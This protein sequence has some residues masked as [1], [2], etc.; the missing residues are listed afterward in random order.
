[1]KKW[2]IRNRKTDYRE[3]AKEFGISEIVSKLL[4]NRDI[5]DKDSI[6]SFINP[7]YENFHNPREMK[8]LVKGVRIIKQKI[9]EGKK[10]MVVGDYDVDGVISLFELYTALKRCS[11]DVVYEIPDRIKDGYGINESIIDKAYDIGV[12]TIIT[13]DN[14]IASI[15]TIKHGKQLDMTIIVT[16][17]HDIPFVETEGGT[18]KNISSEA[19]AIINPKQEDCNYKFKLLCGAGVA[20]KFIEV[21]YEE[22]GID[23]SEAYKF[24][25]Y[26][27]IATVCD[28]VDLTSENRIFVKNGLELLNE[29]SNLGLT[30]LIKVTGIENKEISVYHLGFVI[31]PSLNAAGRLDSAKKGVALLLSDN[32]EEAV[33]LAKE[34]HELNIQRKDITQQG[35]ERAIEYIENNKMMRDK[36]LVVYTPE[37]H[38]S[39]AGIVAGRIREKYNLPAIVLTKAK[40]GVKGSAR[41]IEVY[42]MF[43][44]LNKC[45]ELLGPFG[46]H[47]MAAGLSL[48]EENI[49]ELRK[50]LNIQTTLTDEDIIP[51][52]YL[53][54]QL[55]LEKID[56]DLINDLSTLEPFGKGNS[57]PLF[58]EKG[59]T[60]VRGT[61]LGKNKNVLKLKMIMRNGVYIDGI[62]F[63]DINEFED[64]ITDKYGIDELNRLYNGNCRLKLDM[65]FYPSINEFNGRVSIQIVVENFR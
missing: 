7:S 19:D 21:L 65:V 16:D 33:K 15:D 8:D 17:H 55:P 26:I 49:L 32:Q 13:C 6:K 39:I 41:S 29:T 31:G 11:A 52:L 9:E 27:A 1:L 56:Y 47:P 46:G 12:D 24:I 60:V 58:G 54:M 43:E 3:I 35:V 20:F 4:V 51:K 5:I 14:G 48:K 42:N 40:D 59:V 57:K 45:K 62:Y 53:D 44:E 18:R 50:K 61:I 38:E 34:L 10:I 28:V 64:V 2:F 37:T 25:E 23:K 22:M 63:G 36:V 30:E